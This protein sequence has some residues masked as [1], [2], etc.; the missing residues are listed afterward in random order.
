M[1]QP[2][3]V[4]AAEARKV[5][6]LLRAD[7]IVAPLPAMPEF[8][9]GV[10]VGFEKQGDGSV[11]TR[12]VITVHRWPSLELVEYTIARVP[13]TFPYIPGFLSFRECPA[14]L[15]AWEQL[16]TKP[17][18][19]FCD[20]QGMAHPRRFGVACHLGVLLDVPAIGVAK[21]RLIGRHD[22]VAAMKGSTT[23]LLDGDE[24]IG[25]VLRSRNNVKPLYI[26][27]GHRVTLDQA[28]E[29]VDGACRGYRLPEPTR[30]AD[31]IASRRSGILKKLPEWNLENS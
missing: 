9:A 17:G 6:E 22:D 13:T 24:V 10:D 4:S 16:T 25:T 2:W 14:V 7:V 15:K 30:W 19:L 28:V 23:P 20:G 1:N 18:L 27:V 3:P 31:G 26:S 21:S 29:L 12:G 8:V 11:L 5:Q